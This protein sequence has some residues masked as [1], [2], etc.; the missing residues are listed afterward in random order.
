M[1]ESRRR[2]GRF[3]H[4]I[5]PFQ[6]IGFRGD[7]PAM[8]RWGSR[9]G[10][11]GRVHASQWPPLRAAAWPPGPGRRRS[12]HTAPPVTPGRS[13]GKNCVIRTASVPTLLNSA[14]RTGCVHEDRG[15]DGRVV[16]GTP[17]A[18]AGVAGRRGGWSRP[19]GSAGGRWRRRAPRACPSA[20][21]PPRPSSRPRGCTRSWP[22]PTSMSWT[23]RWM[24]CGR[25]AGRPGRPDVLRAPS[26]DYAKAVGC[27]RLAHARP[28]Q[29]P[30]T[31]LKPRKC[32]EF[33]TDLGDIAVRQP[34]KPR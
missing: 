34:R 17:G 29:S 28:L 26:Y 18:A 3:S 10:I 33:E 27:T 22:P 4:L 32:H 11:C 8:E 15:A 14:R 30:A 25:R 1:R 16:P 12:R 13:A 24:S 5:I 9:S 6:V 2:G 7:I 19:N 31:R 23:R 20:H 21:S